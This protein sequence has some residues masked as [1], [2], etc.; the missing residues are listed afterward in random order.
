MMDVFPLGKAAD[1]TFGEKHMDMGIPLEVAAE[2]VQT[3]Y[4]ASGKLLPLI[5][6]EKPVVDYLRRGAKQ[7][8]KKLTVSAEVGA[9][10]FRDGKDDMAVPAVDQFQGNAVGTI[11]LV[12]N[13]TGIAETGMAAKGDKLVGA[14]RRADIQG[15]SHRGIAAA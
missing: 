5:L 8:V 14:A 7:D 3:H 6:L 9:E 10:F 15:V 12:S 11:R 2:S 4:H 1:C 13:A